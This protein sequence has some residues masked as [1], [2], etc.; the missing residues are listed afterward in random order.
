[1]A[2]EQKTSCCPRILSSA[3]RRQRVIP[4]SFQLAGIALNLVSVI[5]NEW[6]AG[7][8]TGLWFTVFKSTP[9]PWVA[10]FWSGSERR[11]AITV[12]DVTIPV[13]CWGQGPPVVMMHGWSGSGTQFRYFIP[14]LVEAGFAAVCFD[15]PEHGGN[16]GRQ[17]HMLR[18]SASLLAIQQQLGQLDCVIAHSLGAMAATYAMQCG[19]TPKRAVLV[20]P[21]LD[22]QKMFETYRDLLKMRP[23]LAQRFHDKIGSRMQALMDNADPWETLLP[24]KLLASRDL[25]GMLVYDHEDPEVAPAQFQQMI[26]HWRDCRVHNTRGLGHNRILKDEAVIAAIVDYL[27]S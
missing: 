3:E 12:D 25:P 21:H 22:V 7:V 11:L 16:P 9:K 15:A 17:T 2:Q 1:M 20:A 8:L 14:A 19:L 23:A 26:E 13:H 27:K 4:V 24:A 18:F 6:A 5:H 10:G